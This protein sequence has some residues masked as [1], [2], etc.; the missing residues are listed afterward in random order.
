MIPYE[1][2][3]AALDRYRANQGAA[4]AVSPSYDGPTGQT[5][6]PPGEEEHTSVGVD[7]VYDDHSNELDIG[8]V[9]SDEEAT[10][11]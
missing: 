9:V 11:H 2:L 3:C 10:N 6:L 8:D 7:A 5:A 4:A 1:E